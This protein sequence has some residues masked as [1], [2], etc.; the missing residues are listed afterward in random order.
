MVL[1]KFNF[2]KLNT[3]KATLFTWLN[4]SFLIR[5]EQYLL[6]VQGAKSI[7]FNNSYK[8]YCVQW[9]WFRFWQIFVPYVTKAI[10][11]SMDETLDIQL[12]PWFAI[13]NSALKR[14]SLKKMLIFMEI[15]QNFIQLRMD[16][17]MC[18]SYATWLPVSLWRRVLSRGSLPI[19]AYVPPNWS[20][21]WKFFGSRQVCY[22]S[23]Y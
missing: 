4:K 16:V 20:I 6:V 13:S 12:P 14:N 7:I 21:K 3:S 9:L 22:M 8:I 10:F 2:S 19:I 18:V 23:N 5:G 17:V 15:L 11:S 1:L